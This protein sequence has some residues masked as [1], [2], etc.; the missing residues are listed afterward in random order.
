MEENR[1]KRVYLEHQ[2]EKQL[3][4]SSVV[5]NYNNRFSCLKDNNV[6]PPRSDAGR[7]EC[8]RG[9][10][11]HSEQDIRIVNQESNRFSCLA[12]ENYERYPRQEI[13]RTTYLPRPEPRESVNERARRY[14]EEKKTV[15]TPPPPPMTFQSDYHFPELGKEQE[16]LTNSKLPKPAKEVKLPEQKAPINMIVNPI[17]APVKKDKVLILSFKDGKVTQKEMYD[18]GTEIMEAAPIIIK[19]PTYTSWASVLKKS[20]P[21]PEPIINYDQDDE[22]YSDFSSDD[23]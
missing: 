13:Q 2:R 8:L 23:I 10:L 21:E 22:E 5:S 6:A 15:S 18:D 3:E 20:E 17:I 9:S 14:Q 16:V 1:F 19:K 12:S 11:N 7:F 4:R